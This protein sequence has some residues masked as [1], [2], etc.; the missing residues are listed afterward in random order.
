MLPVVPQQLI[1][2][3]AQASW[4]H[5]LEAD[6]PVAEGNEYFRRS[7]SGRERLQIQLVLRKSLT[8]LKR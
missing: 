3:S 2:D 4:I 6:L 7:S 8:D 5:T 1:A